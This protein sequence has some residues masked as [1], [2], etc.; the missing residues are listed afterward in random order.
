M[1]IFMKFR[2]MF[3][4]LVMLPA[5]LGRADQLQFHWLEFLYRTGSFARS[6]G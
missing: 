1:V 5:A 3:P 4:P 6:R 2:I